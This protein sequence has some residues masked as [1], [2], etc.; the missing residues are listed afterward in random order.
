[1]ILPQLRSGTAHLHERVERAVDLLGRLRS[2]ES[3]THLLARYYGFY[4]PFEDRL[5][6]VVGDVPIGLDLEAR[7]KTPLLQ[8]DLVALGHSEAAIE[9]LPLCPSLPAPS[10]LDEVFGCLYVLEGATLGGQIVRKEIKRE[11]GLVAGHGA[12]FF[13]SYGDDVGPMWKAFCA[14]LE[15][16]ARRHPETEH[17]VVGAAVATFTCFEQWFAA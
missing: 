9:A 4:K 16:H 3:Y 13:S 15:D 2:L 11:Y 5:A 10:G 12:S 8:N 7:L 14:A 1:M 17:L 6:G